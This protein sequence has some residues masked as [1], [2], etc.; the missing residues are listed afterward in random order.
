MNIREYVKSLF[1]RYRFNQMKAT[2]RIMKNNLKLLKGG[3]ED[4]R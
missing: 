4:A 3:K 1:I 2:L